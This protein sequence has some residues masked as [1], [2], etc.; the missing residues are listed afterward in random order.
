MIELP[1]GVECIIDPK[2]AE[3]ISQYPDDEGLGLQD[4]ISA[5]QSGNGRGVVW[6]RTSNPYEN[7]YLVNFGGIGVTID[8]D[9]IAPIGI[10]RDELKEAKMA[11]DDHFHPKHVQNFHTYFDVADEIYPHEDSMYSEPETLDS[12]EPSAIEEAQKA[13]DHFGLPWPPHLPSAQEFG[14]DNQKH[15]ENAHKSSSTETRTTCTNCQQPIAE[16]E[17]GWGH[18]KG[19]P[20]T[21][22]TNKCPGGKG[23]ATP[24]KAKEASIMDKMAKIWPNAQDGDLVEYAN[25]LVSKRPPEWQDK[26]NKTYIEALD[27]GIHDQI[28]LPAGVEKPRMNP[29][30]S[31]TKENWQDLL[32]SEVEPG[33]EI[34]TPHNGASWSVLDVSSDSRGHRIKHKGDP[35]EGMYAPS[36]KTVRVLKRNPV[37]ASFEDEYWDSPDKWTRMLGEHIS[38]PEGLEDY[39]HADEWFQDVELN[40]DDGSEKIPEET[41]KKF[42]EEYN[43]IVNSKSSKGVTASRVQASIDDERDKF[44]NWLNTDGRDHEGKALWK[45]LDH[46]TEFLKSVDPEGTVHNPDYARAALEFSE[47]GDLERTADGDYPGQCD[48]CE[49][50]EIS[51]DGAC[52]NCGFDGE[53]DEIERFKSKERN[54]MDQGELRVQR[55]LGSTEEEKP[56]GETQWDKPEE[57]THSEMYGEQDA[58]DKVF[59][60]PNRNEDGLVTSAVDPIEQARQEIEAGIND[61]LADN[62]DALEDDIAFD[63]TQSILMYHPPEVADEVWRMTTGD[64]VFPNHPSRAKKPQPTPTETKPPGYDDWK[65]TRQPVYDRLNDR[66]KRP[67]SSTDPEVAMYGRSMTDPDANRVL[68]NLDSET[69]WL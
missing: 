8:A 41:K 27:R 50:E 1:Q 36:D 47:P 3:Y 49:Q 68:D 5:I 32:P 48:R 9:H 51:P 62:P 57:I 69:N 58:I 67:I 63:V 4:V 53:M 34:I 10:K 18:T 20:N 55:A 30:T 25:H 23:T 19:G 17:S 38:N 33:D 60:K 65:K 46:Y 15:I 35:H 61:T 28:P 12:M 40:T 37:K 52:M 22:W 26:W 11:S 39:L 21:G 59:V 6:E 45:Q 14:L 29:T 44:Y 43:R 16:Y 31:A 66:K 24:P 13:S 64:P 2:A 7:K 56:W 54:Q 42:R